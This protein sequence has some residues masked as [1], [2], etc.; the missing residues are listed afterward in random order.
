[1]ITIF[2][3]VECRP[4]HFL[5]LFLSR[6]CRFDTKRSIHYSDFEAILHYLS[7]VYRYLEEGSPLFRYILTQGKQTISTSIGHHTRAVLQLGVLGLGT[8]S[9]LTV[10]FSS[11]VQKPFSPFPLAFL[12]KWVVE[13]EA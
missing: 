3:F 13:G 11:S 5:L 10:P 6:L 1:M 2:S 12:W 7:Y 8:G 9:H 4:P